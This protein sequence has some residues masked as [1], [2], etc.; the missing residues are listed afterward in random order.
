MAAL[1]NKLSERLHPRLAKWFHETFGDFTHAQLLC[2]PAIGNRSCSLRQ[3]AA[4]KHRRDF[5][6]FS[7]FLLRKY[8]DHTL[9]RSVQCIYVSPLRALAYEI[10]KNLRAHHRN[11][12]G[13]RTESALADWRHAGGGNAAS[14]DS[15]RRMPSGERRRGQ[16]SGRLEKEWTLR[17][18]PSRPL[19]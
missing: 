16:E 4:A 6:E 8:D 11:G 10:G 12:T 2:V 17:S 18:T 19:S 15:G 9:P 1:P 3:R 13:E 5:W 7:I 14:S